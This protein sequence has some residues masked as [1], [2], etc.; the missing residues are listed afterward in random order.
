MEISKLA[1][2]R[3]RGTVLVT[4]SVSTG[5]NINS[6]VNQLRREVVSAQNIRDKHD[7]R[8]VWSA[9]NKLLHELPLTSVGNGFLAFAAYDGV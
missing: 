8:A 3:E 9:L 1:E 6:V 5:S 2:R 7:K 4:L